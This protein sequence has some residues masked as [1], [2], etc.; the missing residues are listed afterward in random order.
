MSLNRADCMSAGASRGLTGR[1]GIRGPAA[2]R[3]TAS[4]PK[5]GEA[6]MSRHL[7]VIHELTGGCVEAGRSPTAAP[8]FPEFSRLRESFRRHALRNTGFP[9]I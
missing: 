8:N 6:V 5:P 3:G 1:N 7:C 2:A 4:W 9:L